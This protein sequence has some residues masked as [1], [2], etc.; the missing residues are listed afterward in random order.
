[1]DFAATGIM[2]SAKLGQSDAI[3]APIVWTA[4]KMRDAAAVIEFILQRR[5]EP[6]VSP[7]AWSM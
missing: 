3:N 6:K 7:L 4:M 5:A 2:R 1:M